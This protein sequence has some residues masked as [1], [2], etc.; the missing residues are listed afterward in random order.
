MQI[1]WS[2]R[3]WR[4]PV[5]LFA[6]GITVDGN[7]MLRDGFV[8]R[9]E[10]RLNGSKIG[11]NL[12]C[13]GASVSNLRGHTLSAAGAHVEGSIYLCQTKY[14]DN[15][16]VFFSEG[17]LRLEGASVSGDVDCSGGRF[18]AAAFAEQGW[19]PSDKNQKQLDAIEADGLKVGA[20]LIFASP[21]DETFLVHGSVRLINVKVGGDF[22]CEGAYFN[23]AG[24][25]PL[26]ADGISVSG[27]TFFG[28][29]ETNGMLRFVKASLEQGFYLNGL[30]LDNTR[31]WNNWLRDNSSARV[32]GAANTGAC[33]IYAPL[34]KVGGTFKWTDVEKRAEFGNY[35]LWL[36]LPGSK[37]DVVEDNV[38]SWSNL[39]NF[40]VT[41]CDY[42]IITNLSG[43]PRRRLRE[44]DRQ[45]AVLNRRPRRRPPLPLRTL[46]RALL[47]CL[48]LRDRL[49]AEL[50]HAI[51]RFKPQPY[52]QLAKT[53]RNAGYEPAAND[54]LVGLERNRT[55]YS[56]FGVLRQLGRRVL[57]WGLLYGF[58][59]FRP[60]LFL[61]IWVLLSSAI[62]CVAFEQG[63]I[64]STTTP[65]SAF[66]PILYSVDTL[67]PIVDFNQK[68]N[69]TIESTAWPEAGH[70][71]PALP[72]WLAPSLLV[73]NTF[74]GWLMTTLFAAGIS[75]LLRTGKEGG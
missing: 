75:G 66:E 23:F 7:V 71:W 4:Q 70:A 32:V 72:D 39:D 35:P 22:D 57:D 34:A 5:P 41:D 59:P 58:S 33:G 45:Y 29:V 52:I 18:V 37:A 47:R 44:L 74:F 19:Q 55:H 40:D 46:F 20:D 51:R 61:A 30:R 28:H 42:E 43:D 60:V 38:A 26:V 64:I 73:F 8:A 69:W 16:D 68:K 49:D 1:A 6:D 17:A 24:E 54:V 48:P 31:I 15:R 63:R 65:P 67:V 56:D 10:I 25:E 14:G 9:G 21:N 2:Q 36:Y 27:T 53:F 12:D 50:R 11:R 3:R 62:F 13:S